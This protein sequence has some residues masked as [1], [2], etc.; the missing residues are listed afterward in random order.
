MLNFERKKKFGH[1]SY[2]NLSHA[3]GNQ[4]KFWPKIQFSQMF[5]INLKL[6]KSCTKGCIGDI[7]NKILQKK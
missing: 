2:Y 3:P 5:K 7:E 4:Q 6:F 1:R